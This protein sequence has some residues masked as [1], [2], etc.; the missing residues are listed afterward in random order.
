MKIRLVLVD[1]VTDVDVPY[2]DLSVRTI[3]EDDSVVDGICLTSY[4]GVVSIYCSES[5][6][7]NG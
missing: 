6:D 1:K 5:E 3:F 2:P 7:I 4:D